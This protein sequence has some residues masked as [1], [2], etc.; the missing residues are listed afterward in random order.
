LKEESVPVHAVGL[1]SHIHQRGA[2]IPTPE[3]FRTVIR[4]FSGLDL[5]VFITELDVSI[6]TPVTAEDLVEQAEIYE[7]LVEVCVSE[8]RCKMLT[9]WDFT[10]KYSWIPEHHEGYDAATPFDEDHEEKPAYYAVQRA[11]EG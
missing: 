5:D 11:L 2:V 6:K 7:G 8:P 4:E 10:D 3:E 9:L 1:Q